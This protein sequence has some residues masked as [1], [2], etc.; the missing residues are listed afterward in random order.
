MN[1]DA[2]ERDFR[3]ANPGLPADG[4]AVTCDGRRLKEVRICLTHDLAFTDCDEVDRGGCRRPTVVM[5]PVR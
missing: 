5:P 4:I 1:P 3:A 2:V